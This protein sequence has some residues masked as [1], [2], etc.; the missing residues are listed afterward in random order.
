MVN[1][2]HLTGSVPNTG[3]PGI[4]LGESTTDAARHLQAILGWQTDTESMTS[5]AFHDSEKLAAAPEFDRENTA[6]WADGQKGL[7]GSH[8]AHFERT[9][10]MY[11]FRHRV[12]SLPKPLREW[13]AYAFRNFN[14]VKIEEQVS[15]AVAAVCVLWSQV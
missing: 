9:A 8:H 13:Y 14:A 7:A 1:G 6:C 4:L 12:E 3:L 15:L 10:L 5:W 11:D 2:F